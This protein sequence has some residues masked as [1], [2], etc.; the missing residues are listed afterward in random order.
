MSGRTVRE[1]R[2]ASPPSAG[3][4]HSGQQ[5]FAEIV[6]ADTTMSF[7]FAASPDTVPTKAFTNAVSAIACAV[8]AFTAAET[9]A[10]VGDEVAGWEAASLTTFATAALSA[11]I[12]MRRAAAAAGIAALAADTLA[13]PV[14]VAVTPEAT[15]G[16][17][18][19]AIGYAA[20]RTTLSPLRAIELPVDDDERSASNLALDLR[21]RP[22]AAKVLSA[23][24]RAGSVVAGD[25]AIVVLAVVDVVDEVVDDAEVVGDAVP[26]PALHPARRQTASA[27]A[28]N[29]LRCI[30]ESPR[31]VIGV[32][33]ASSSHPE[34]VVC[35][36]LDDP[37]RGSP[38]TSGRR[39]G[40]C[41]S[42]VSSGKSAL[43]E[44]SATIVFAGAGPVVGHFAPCPG[45]GR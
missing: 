42:A 45:E 6:V 32:G 37:E 18:R 28:P 43:T 24:A 13:A 33:P 20:A 30:A 1:R 27:T 34:T 15:R 9:S 10:G 12:C 11:A 8:A 4:G 36:K 21:S 25:V 19:L 7:A 39:P 31:H 44:S 16:Q 38:A 14:R 3:P 29:V 22:R 2:T 35:M 40:T 23:A 17:L 26:S 5:T 41:E